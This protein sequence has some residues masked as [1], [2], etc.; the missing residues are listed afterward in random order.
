V[1]QAW[2]IGRAALGLAVL[3]GIGLLLD[4]SVVEQT[5][6]EV[7]LAWFG[8]ALVGAITANLLC[9]LRWADISAFLGIEVPKARFIS[10]YGQGIAINVVLP[11]GVIGGDA[12]RTSQLPH[13][14]SLR[15]RLESVWL[16][17]LSGLWA[18]ALI[19]LIALLIALIARAPNSLWGEFLAPW[20]W[21]YLAGLAVIASIPIFYK[22]GPLKAGVFSI[23]SQVITIFSFWLCLKATSGSIELLSLLFIAPAIFIAAMT[24]ASIGGFGAREGASVFFLG[25]LGV[26]AEAAT[27]GSLLFG[28]TAVIQG[29]IATLIWSVPKVQSEEEPPNASG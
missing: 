24:P 10:L 28:L 7:N 14:A 6:Q 5:L 9:A 15:T 26:S 18:L 19:A 25:F 29:V 1:R 13:M 17:R 12:W 16:D 11:G 22:L 27:I 23:A 3:I 2:A 20:S 8:L 4:W 21:V